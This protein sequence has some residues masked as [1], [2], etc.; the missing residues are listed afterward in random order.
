M[1]GIIR[2]LRKLKAA[3]QSR[4]EYKKERTE[5]QKRRLEICKKCPFNSNNV[6]QLKNKDKVAIQFNKFLNF[7]FGVEV[8]DEA[9]CTKCG[10]NLIHKST[11]TEEELKCPEKKW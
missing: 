6:K 4:R 8:D 1:N 10:C 7:I 11:Q 3:I 2:N 5:E 9:I